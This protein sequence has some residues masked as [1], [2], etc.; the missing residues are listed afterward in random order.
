MPINEKQRD[1]YLDRMSRPACVVGVE[2]MD[3][4]RV[5]DE[6]LPLKTVVMELSTERNPKREVVV[7]ARALKQ[8]LQREIQSLEEKIRT[9]DVDKKEADRILE[10]A[11]SLK[12][13]VVD[14]G[15][16]GKQVDFDIHAITEKE[17]EDARRWATFLKGIC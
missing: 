8:L 1:W 17:V 2:I 15:S 4:F 5:G 9:M 3:H 13:A 6:Y 12:R 10:T 16:V 7:K 14:L 11:L